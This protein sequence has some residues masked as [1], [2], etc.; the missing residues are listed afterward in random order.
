LRNDFL[1]AGARRF[2]VRAVAFVC[3][4]VALGSC[5][6]D[7]DVCTNPSGEFC[8]V[9]EYTIDVFAETAGTYGALQFDIRHLGD[10]GGFVGH[11][12]K[13]D[14]VSLV[15]DVI[16]ASNYLGERETKIGIISLQGVST[17]AALLRCGFRTR[18]GLTPADFEIEVTDSSD[19]NSMQVEPPVVKVQSIVP[20]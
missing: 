6:D 19:T 20:R 7:V 11:G 3:A 17:P 8:P 2:A 14:C 18:E 10:S 15:A 12:D 1:N 9:P 13:V 4:A 5:G 16:V